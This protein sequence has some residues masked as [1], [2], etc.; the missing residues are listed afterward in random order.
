MALS[1]EA[2][3]FINTHLDEIEEQ[4]PDVDPFPRDIE[5]LEAEW[6][7]MTR[8][9]CVEEFEDCDEESDVDEF[10]EENSI[11]AGKTMHTFI[12]KK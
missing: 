12:F 10:M 6:L 2:L 7:E 3:A 11:I 5:T 4:R 9:Q 1:V 8:A